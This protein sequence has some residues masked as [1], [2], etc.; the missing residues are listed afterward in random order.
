[1]GNYLRPRLISI[2]IVSMLITLTFSASANNIKQYLSIGDFHE[3]YLWSVLLQIL[4][5]F[6]SLYHSLL[7][8]MEGFLCQ[9][10]M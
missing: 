9:K 1:M 3:E 4:K 6:G 2:T 10:K 7:D 5:Q 8:F